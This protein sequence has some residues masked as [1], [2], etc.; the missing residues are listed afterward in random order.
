MKVE[1]IWVGDQAPVSITVLSLEMEIKKRQ[2]PSII[3]LYYLV[4][5]S[6]TRMCINMSSTACVCPSRFAMQP[7]LKQSRPS[8][9]RDGFPLALVQ[10]MRGF[11]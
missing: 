3:S 7:Y 9:V 5:D 2:K 1:Y 11:I 4:S 8:C 6:I 10:G